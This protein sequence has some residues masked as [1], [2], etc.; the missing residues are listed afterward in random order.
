MNELL[1]EYIQVQNLT[2][3]MSQPFCLGAANHS[4]AALRNK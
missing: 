1:F 3:C 2:T 4:A